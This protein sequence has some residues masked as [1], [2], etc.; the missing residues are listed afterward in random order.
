MRTLPVALAYHD[1]ETMLRT[2]ARLSAMTHWDAQAEVCCAVYCL[3]VEQLLHGASLHEGWR[4]A[5]TV[6]RELAEGAPLAPDTVGPQPLP[7]GFWERLE[8]VEQLEY[9]DLQPSG[10]AGYVVECLEA[11][12]WCCLRSDS[13]EECLVQAV[14]LAGQADTIAAVAGGIAGAHW[15]REAIPQR[16]LDALYRGK[17]VEATAEDL[18]Q[19]RRH[20]EVYAKE[21]LPPLNHDWI[22]ERIMAG[23]NL[24]TSRDVDLKKA[25][26]ITHI[27]DLRE[28][29][30]W[31]VPQF[32]A[33]AV[34]EIDR[35]GL[36]R[37]HLP[38]ID[39]GAPTRADL[40]A[41]CQYLQ[42]VL[43]DPDARIYVHCRAGMERTAAVLVAYHA[44]EQG[45]TYDEALA[46][47]SKRRLAFKPLLNQEKAVRQ[48]LEEQRKGS[49]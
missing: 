30:E 24:L 5:L 3:W 44:R 43:S 10:Y 19:L 7:N 1:R 28:P 33:E 23:R 37:L 38:V 26:G 17:E 49:G 22:D 15:G 36:Q 27:L 13:L 11:A 34:D 6:G 21:G 46:A 8:A 14:N 9:A 12:A 4:A 32:G 25:Q 2:S 20:R 41:A 31:A 18:I 48:W 29:H 39:Q 45:L 42:E 16:W 40:E 47:L 35:C